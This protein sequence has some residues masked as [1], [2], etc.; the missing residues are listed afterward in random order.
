M[1]NQ[2]TPTLFEQKIYDALLHIPK[3]RVTTYKLLAQTLRCR[4]AQ[5][6][7]QALKRNPFAPEVPCHRVIR[8]DHHL[9]GFQGKRAGA[10]IREKTRLLEQEG[11]LFNPEG[12]LI[13]PDRIVQI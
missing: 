5:A 4:S 11:V 10:S 2:R 6:I 1:K 12:F 13:D 8:S 9:G 7:G 3:G